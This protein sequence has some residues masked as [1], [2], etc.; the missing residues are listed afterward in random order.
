M[1]LDWVIVRNGPGSWAE[2]ADWD[3]YL[4]RVS[5]NSEVS[6][7]ITSATVFD[8]LLTALETSG[9]RTHLIDESKKTTE[10][11][12]GQGLSVQLS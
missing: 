2:D 1:N 6:V 11:Y 9:Q 10:R 5:N 8:S 4:V 12:S 3:E 7:R